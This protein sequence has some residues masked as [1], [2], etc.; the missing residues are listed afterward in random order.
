[1]FSYR[2]GFH[3]GNHADVLKHCIMTRVLRHLR[4]KEKPFWYVDTHAGAALYDLESAWAAKNAEFDT[5]IARLWGRDD[6]PELVADYVDQVRACNPDGELRLYPGS[7]WLALQLLGDRDRLRLFEL[8]GSEVEV[9]RE[10]LAHQG[11]DVARRTMIYAADGFTGIKAL[12]PPPTRRGVVLIDPSYEDKQDYR[13]VLQSVQDGLERFATGC[14]AVWYPR[15]QRRDAEQLAERLTAVPGV[16]NW[17]HA[18]ISVSAAREDGLGLHGSGMFLVNPPWTLHA[19]LAEVLPWLT[20]V[21]AQDGR[22]SFTL[23]GHQE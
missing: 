1:M 6:L 10:T 9:L 2:H 21:L 12:L 4:Q 16:R 19:E 5:G 22:A 3:A 13:R 8:H 15:V 23:Q 20:E 14:Y 7:P 11:R 17:L 18:A